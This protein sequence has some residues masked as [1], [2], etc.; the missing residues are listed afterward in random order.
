[1]QEETSLLDPKPQ[2]LQE[3]MQCFAPDDL[4]SWFSAAR[5][6]ITLH[7]AAA[8]HHSTRADTAADRHWQRAAVPEQPWTSNSQ[9]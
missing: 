7:Q 4:P 2:C 5:A 1:M 3:I 6:H 8:E 9:C